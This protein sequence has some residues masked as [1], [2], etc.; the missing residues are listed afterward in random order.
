MAYCERC[1]SKLLG[2]EFFL[3]SDPVAATD[4][5]TGALVIQADEVVRLAGLPRSEQAQWIA[6]RRRARVPRA[7]IRPPNEKRKTI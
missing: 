5:P 2:G 1:Y 6:D 7:R 3:A 4:A